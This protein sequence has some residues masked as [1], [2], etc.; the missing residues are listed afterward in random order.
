MTSGCFQKSSASKGQR[1]QD[2]EDIQKRVTT[3]L[4][5]ILQWEFQKCFQQ[6]PELLG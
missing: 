3:A 1:L 6:W 2:G 4:K 5:A